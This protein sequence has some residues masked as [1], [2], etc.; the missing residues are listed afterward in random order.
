L[1]SITVINT[2]TKAEEEKVYFSS[3]LTAH[4]GGDAGQENGDQ[5]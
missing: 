1:L 5:N 2:M 3:E 4:H